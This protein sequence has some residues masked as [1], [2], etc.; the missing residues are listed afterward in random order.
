M[1]EGAL[2]D[3][4]IQT[5][6]ACMMLLQ[7]ALKL[8]CFLLTHFL[9]LGRKPVLPMSIIL[10]L[11]LII[12]ICGFK[13]VNNQ[14]PVQKGHTYGSNEVSIAKHQDKLRYVTIQGGGYHP[15]PWHFEPGDYAYPQQTTTTTLAVIVGGIILHVRVIYLL[16]YR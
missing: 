11:T 1:L 3:W 7:Q 2:G 5:P 9:L 13:L 10:L 16:V 14:L 4:D 12:R 6:L 8:P 15:R